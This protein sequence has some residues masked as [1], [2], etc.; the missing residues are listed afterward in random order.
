M[1]SKKVIGSNETFKI[2][3][4]ELGEECTKVQTL[5][6]QMQ[7][8]QL[9]ASQQAEILAKLLASVTHLHTHC[10]DELQEMIADELEMLPDDEEVEKEEN[11]KT[12][13]SQADVTET[14][15][16]GNK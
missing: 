11:L 15:M 5:L 2:L 6:S 16:A 13:A 14:I 4:S 12:M 7:T 10:D 3:I 9:S 8:P 1:K